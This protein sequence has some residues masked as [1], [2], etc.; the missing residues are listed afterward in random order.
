MEKMAY[1]KEP[2]VFPM[3]G[4]AKFTVILMDPVHAAD[5]IKLLFLKPL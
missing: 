1:L 4:T 5:A 2:L 3:P